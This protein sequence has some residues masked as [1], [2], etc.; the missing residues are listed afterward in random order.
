MVPMKLVDLQGSE[1]ACEI[2]ASVQHATSFQRTKRTLQQRSK[3][4]RLTHIV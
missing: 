2:S 4:G 1:R 3:I